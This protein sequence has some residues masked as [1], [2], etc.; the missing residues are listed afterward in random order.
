M[1][2]PT[3]HTDYGEEPEPQVTIEAEHTEKPDVEIARI[4]ADRDIKLAKISA[5]MI[6]AE[7]VAETAHAEGVAEG[8][9][10]ALHPEPEAA[11]ETAPVVVVNDDPAPEEPAAEPLP[12]AEPS[13]EPKEHKHSSNFWGA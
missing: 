4:Q 2:C 1:H 13:H 11:P 10:E 6:E 9:A 3:C 8:M 7:Q 12:E 5:G